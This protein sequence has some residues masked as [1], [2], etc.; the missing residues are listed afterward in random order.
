MRVEDVADKK[1]IEELRLALADMRSTRI[2][3]DD[4]RK[5]ST[6][7]YRDAIEYINWDRDWET[8]STLNFFH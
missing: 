7:P 5:E 2:E 1:K 4:Q 6:K 8:S 3:L